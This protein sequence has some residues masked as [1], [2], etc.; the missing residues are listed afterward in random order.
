MSVVGETQKETIRPDFDKSISIDFHGAKITSDTGFLLLREVDERFGLLAPTA[1]LI[2]DPRSASHT[3]HSLLQL[4]RRRVYQVAAGYEDCND[5]DYL[6]VDPALRLAL[7]KEHDSGA[8]QSGLCR[9]ENDILATEDGIKG[10]E[11]GLGRFADTLLR[12][13]NKSRLILDVDSTKDSVHGKQEGAAFNGHFEEV[14]YHP[15]FCLTSNG[16]LWGAKL[17]PGNAHSADGILEL[18]SPLV[19]R[20]RPRFRQFW[21]RGNAAFA[22]PGIY[23]FCEGKRITY[24]IRISCN[25]S[26]KKLIQPHLKRPVGRPSKEGVQVKFVDLEYQAQTWDRPRRV[27]CKM[28]WH[29]GELF[30]RIG[31]IVTN[32]RLEA[33]KICQVQSRQDSRRKSQI[34]EINPLSFNKH[35]RR[36]L[37]V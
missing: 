14:C 21:L 2:E 29:P 33:V 26:L 20:Y 28:E 12:R 36:Y 11:A 23:E 13:R 18:I 1:S 31:F 19:E 27:V 7:G 17:R 5:A 37:Q 30:P 16:G 25:N 6:R 22:G 4:L 32:F 35:A 24:F 8:C 10:P 9:F 15:L 34:A 3:K